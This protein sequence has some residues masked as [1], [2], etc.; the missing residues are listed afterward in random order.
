VGGG[1]AD[2]DQ[3]AGGG[4]CDN[5]GDEPELMVSHEKGDGANNDGE[6]GDEAGV[7][8]ANGEGSFNPCV[9]EISIVHGGGASRLW[10]GGRPSWKASSNNCASQ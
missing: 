1:G 8:G 10:K 3:Y 9:F 5:T 2:S 6:K 4:V 7:D